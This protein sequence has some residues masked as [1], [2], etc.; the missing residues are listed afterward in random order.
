[1]IGRRRRQAREEARL[2]A[3]V[4]RDAALAARWDCL[5]GYEQLGMPTSTSGIAPAVLI[6]TAVRQVAARGLKGYADVLGGPRGHAVWFEGFH[7]P[8]GP[9]LFVGGRY[10]PVGRGQ[11]HGEPVFW[12][13]VIWDV[14]PPDAPAAWARDGARRAAA[15]R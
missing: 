9:I 10:W 13:D 2:A 3:Q 7:P 8:V 6:V 11:H 1:M 4:A 14:L 12:V 15:V 5:R